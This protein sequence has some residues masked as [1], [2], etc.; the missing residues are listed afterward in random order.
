M[1]AAL[2]FVSCKE[3]LEPKS[4]SEFSPSTLEQLSELILTAI[5]EPF[6]N[7]TADISG[8]FLDILTDDVVTATF[9]RQAGPNDQWYTFPYVT[10]IYAMYT[11]QP[12]YAVLMQQA[13]FNH[14]SQIYTNS[15]QRLVYV[16]STLDYADRLNG[17]E[18]LRKYIKAQA[19]TL[20]ALFYL[21]LVNV[22]GVPY[23]VD[24]DGPGVPLRT[25]GARENRP[26]VRNTVGEAYELIVGDLLYALE[27]FEQ[28]PPIR[29]FSRHT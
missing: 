3:F 22:Y 11:W 7:T 13:G 27:L 21:H 15:Y 26:M 18:T 9:R 16:N 29:Q 4:Q 1:L 19:H 20:R 5:P 12:N 2:T 25:T 24:P 6:I 8:G 14:F 28:L 17:D 23:N 10:G